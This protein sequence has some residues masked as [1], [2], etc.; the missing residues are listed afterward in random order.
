MT[1]IRS[2]PSGPATQEAMEE[3]LDD[4]KDLLGVKGFIVGIVFAD[5]SASSACSGLSLRDQALAKF[6]I[7]ENM[8]DAFK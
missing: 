3:F 4:L 2:L 7:E 6:V 1:N 5:G 8:R